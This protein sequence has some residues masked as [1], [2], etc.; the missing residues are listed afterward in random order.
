MSFVNSHNSSLIRKIADEKSSYPNLPELYKSF[1]YPVSLKFPIQIG[2]TAYQKE[3]TDIL[4]FFHILTT[5]IYTRIIQSQKTELLNTFLLQENNP[6]FKDKSRVLIKAV[7]EF[8][9]SRISEDKFAETIQDF[10]KNTVGVRLPVISFLL[11]CMHP[12]KFATI[13]YHVINALISLGFTEIKELPTDEPNI[14]EYFRKFSA[15]DYL[16]Y[17]K[18]LSEIGEQFTIQT[19]KGIQ[20]MNPSKVDMALFTFD[21][22]HFKNYSI[23]HN[24]DSDVKDKIAKIKVLIDEIVQ[25]ADEVSKIEWVIKGSYGGMVTASASKL[26][27][28][29]E[30]YA[31]KDDIDGIFSYCLNAL[32]DD[33]GIRVSKILKACNKKTLEDKFPEIEKIYKNNIFS[34]EG[35]DIQKDKEKNDMLELYCKLEEKSLIKTQGYSTTPEQRAE[36][37]KRVGKLA[38]ELLK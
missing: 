4:E 32:S 34:Q 24:M 21:K 15:I 25:G 27:R 31:T 5:K 35:N 20:K 11:R 19:S 13:D 9:S 10:C 26:K 30:S 22:L 7:K 6:N 3:E 18:L 16:N 2:R 1:Q 37:I 33:T 17:I 36:D 23:K 38:D 14:D 29:I 28:V 12:E 8:D